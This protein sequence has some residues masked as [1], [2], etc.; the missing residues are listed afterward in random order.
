[1]SGFLNLSTSERCVALTGAK[2]RGLRHGEVV[3]HR[4]IRGDP[5]LRADEQ[6]TPLFIRREPDKRDAD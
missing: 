3:A 6:M 1:M 4:A 2:R 5:G